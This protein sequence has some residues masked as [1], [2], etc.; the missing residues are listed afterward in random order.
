MYKKFWFK[1][2]QYGWGWYP[3]SWQGWAVLL[4]YIF[5][6]FATVTFVDSHAHSDSDALMGFF[7][8]VYILTVFLIIIC[9]AT[10]QKPRWQWGNEKYDVLNEDGTLSGKRASYT[11]V[12]T[13]GLWHRSVE[14]Y[15]VNSKNEVLL[16]KRSEH[17]ELCP[18]AWHASAA[19]HVGA[20]VSIIEAIKNEAREEIGLVFNDADVIHV[21]TAQSTEVLSHGRMRNSEFKECFLLYAD[22]DIATLHVNKKEVATLAWFPLAEFKKKIESHDPDFIYNAVIPLLFKYLDEHA[23]HKK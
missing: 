18:G 15:V 14:L 7:P 6:V 11:D 2:K 16:Q 8:V 10:G 5:A 23:D 19:G 3:S 12:H 21:A 20:G 4:M 22:I 13:Q 9:Y 17:V 1:A